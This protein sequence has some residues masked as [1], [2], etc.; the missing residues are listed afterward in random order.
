MTSLP[1]I[2]APESK[3]DARSCRT[4]KRFKSRKVLG[5]SVCIIYLPHIRFTRAA[6][7]RHLSAFCCAS[8]CSQPACLFLQRGYQGADG[9]LSQQEIKIKPSGVVLTVVPRAY[10]GSLQHN[11]RGR[12]HVCPVLTISTPPQSTANLSVQIKGVKASLIPEA[13]SP[14]KQIL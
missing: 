5:S 9:S 1:D 13:I 8:Q 6:H 11:I 14:F 7:G 2:C 4:L 12:A 3:D 10:R